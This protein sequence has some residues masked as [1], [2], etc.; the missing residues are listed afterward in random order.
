M[1]P[2]ANLREQAQLSARIIALT[3]TASEADLSPE[4]SAELIESAARLAE[5]SQA[6]CEWITRG[7][8]AA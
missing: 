2:K 8:F 3:D 7:G 5:L 4:E 6:Y 1:D